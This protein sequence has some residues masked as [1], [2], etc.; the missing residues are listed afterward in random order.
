MTSMNEQELAQMLEEMQ[1]GEVFEALASMFAMNSL[2]SVIIPLVTY[3][4]TA[5]ALYTIAN[6]RNI[7]HPWLAWI[8]VAQVWI[9]GSISDQ[10]Q[11]LANERHTNRRKWLVALEIMSF[12]LAVV[13]VVSALGMII[14]LVE[15]G[16][17][18]YENTEDW[19]GALSGIGTVMLVALLICGGSVAKLILQYM[20]MYDLYRSCEPTN[21][22][23]FLVLNIIFGITQPILLMVVRNKDNGMPRP[24]DPISIPAE[25]WDLT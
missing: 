7:A 18:G 21:A 9:L 25:P 23:L 5:L 22:T 17:N 3:I 4:L 20:S 6:R 10:Y 13:M 19:V 14:A 15:A 2:T 16:Y 1:A 12:A 24:A 8:P 11:G